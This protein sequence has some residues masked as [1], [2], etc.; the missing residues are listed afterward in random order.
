M[1]TGSFA[2]FGLFLF[3]P[4]SINFLFHVIRPN[5]Y[6]FFLIMYYTHELSFKSPLTGNKLKTLMSVKP[7]FVIKSYPHRLS[8]FLSPWPN[9]LRQYDY[10]KDVCYESHYHPVSV[11]NNC[12][13]PN[14]LPF[15]PFHSSLNTTLPP[16]DGSSS[17]WK[18]PPDDLTTFS[19]SET[20]SQWH[21]L[22]RDR[23]CAKDKCLEMHYIILH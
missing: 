23:G 6:I 22:R 18:T 5:L 3:F 7:W 21:H 4:F 12:L 10:T 1:I 8:L 16:Q 19:A 17:K 11:I 15:L 9:S 2:W 13:H 20:Q 14:L